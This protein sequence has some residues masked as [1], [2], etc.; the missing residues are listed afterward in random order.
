M[1][2][3]LM[4]ADD[5]TGALDA[6]VAFAAAGA[7]TCVGQYDY[8]AENEE[9]ASCGA[10]V[11]VVPTRHVSAGEA[12]RMVYDTVKKALPLGFSIFC[13]KT[14]SALRGNVGAELEAVL[15]AAEGERL[16]FIPAYPKMGRVTVDGVHYVDGSVPVSESVFA[17]DPFNPV[18]HSAVAEVMAETSQA[19][20]AS[21]VPERPLPGGICVFDASTD[22]DVRRAAEAALRTGGIR[23]FA[24]CAGLAE[25]LA[26]LLDL[27]KGAEAEEIRADRLLVFCGSVNPISRGQ[28][29]AAAENGAPYFHLDGEGTRGD[30]LRMGEEIAGASRKHP[31]VLFD[32]GSPDVDPGAGDPAEAGKRMA[33]RI[34]KVIR[35]A[36]EKA[37]GA[38]PFVIG[39]D[40]LIAFLNGMGVGTVL[41][42]RELFP[43]VV[44]AR[45]RAAGEW[46][47]VISKSGGFGGR[48]LI[49]QVFQKL[50]RKPS[51]TDPDISGQ[52]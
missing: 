51:E 45:Y 50:S 41:P 30:E 37:D 18:R 8:F 15:D 43:G 20:C 46:R 7:D 10:V 9:A 52:G 44:L 1:E 25:A 27:P 36:G 12:Y 47:Y 11:T 28:C 35:R 19:P 5:I 26:G 3:L 39:G 23:L 31:I 48:D 2:R 21:A 33:E 13:K 42:V 6:G 38:V 22:E 32:T 29:A 49:R 40:T 17:R 14:D 24:G 4:I 16:F 34:G